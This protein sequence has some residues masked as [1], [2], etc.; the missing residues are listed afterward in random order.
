M[1]AAQGRRKEAA[2]VQAP[3]ARVGAVQT[4]DEMVLRATEERVRV[5]AVLDASGTLLVRSDA[6]EF[7]VERDDLAQVWEKHAGCGC[8]S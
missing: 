5:V 1:G 2:K 8:C 6:D 7:Q 3:G 4:G